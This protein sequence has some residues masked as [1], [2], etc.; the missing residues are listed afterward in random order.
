MELR[1]KLINFMLE[2][3]APHAPAH[4]PHAAS[5]L[6]DR[7]LALPEIKE[8]LRELAIRKRVEERLAGTADE[9]KFVG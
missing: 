7:I 6:A 5:W 9:R 3:H 2:D 8:A 4:R 1:E